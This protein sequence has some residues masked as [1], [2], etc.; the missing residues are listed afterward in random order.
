MN[1]GT[2][3]GELALS[4]ELVFHLSFLNLNMKKYCF[5]ARIVILEL[6]AKNHSEDLQKISNN[7]HPVD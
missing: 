2:A 4:A 3:L 6:L 1:F 5:I 7:A